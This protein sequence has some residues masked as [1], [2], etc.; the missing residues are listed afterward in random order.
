MRTVSSTDFCMLCRSMV[1]DRDAETE[2]QQ[3]SSKPKSN[4]DA[5]VQQEGFH[6]FPLATDQITHAN[7]TS[8]IPNHTRRINT[9]C[10]INVPP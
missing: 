8:L 5:H 1:P 4:S 3:E 6:G 2:K 9:S 10:V 7:V